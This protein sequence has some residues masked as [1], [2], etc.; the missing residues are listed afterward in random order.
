MYSVTFAYNISL[1]QM[2]HFGVNRISVHNKFSEI[3]NF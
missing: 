1:F 3:Y 2:V